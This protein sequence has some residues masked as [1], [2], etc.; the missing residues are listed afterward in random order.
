MS[1]PMKSSNSF[2]GKLSHLPSHISFYGCSIRRSVANSERG[3]KTTV[4][5]CS[6]GLWSGNPV[7]RGNVLFARCPRECRMGQTTTE[8]E[9]LQS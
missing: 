4:Q 8:D 6:R 7:G 5:Q 3:S 2:V 9:E 1:D